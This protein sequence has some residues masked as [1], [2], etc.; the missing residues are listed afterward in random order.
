[1]YSRPHEYNNTK[2]WLPPPELENLIVA[3]FIISINKGI[4]HVKTYIRHLHGGNDHRPILGGETVF[5]GSFI[6]WIYESVVFLQIVYYQTAVGDK[7]RINDWIQGA[8]ASQ[9]T[10]EKSLVAI[11]RLICQLKTISGLVL[12]LEMVT[13]HCT[14]HVSCY[15]IQG[16]TFDVIR[17]NLYI[18]I[19][20]CA[21]IPVEKCATIE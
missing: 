11:T 13:H 21:N 18:L 6:G 5:V 17:L 9:E 8:V 20:K 19:E 15:F 1:M 3:I 4:V 16:R 2:E 12:C 10:I 14:T 7:F